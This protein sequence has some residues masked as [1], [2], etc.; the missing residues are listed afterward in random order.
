[1]GLMPVPGD[2]KL[3][4]SVTADFLPLRAMPVYAVY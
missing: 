4:F 2:T 3:V 1:M